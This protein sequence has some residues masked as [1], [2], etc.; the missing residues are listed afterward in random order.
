[1]KKP[2]VLGILPC[3]GKKDQTINV[4]QRLLYTA[5]MGRQPWKLVTVSGAEDAEVVAATEA[6]GAVGLVD[7]SRKKLSYWEALQYATDA[8]PDIP[9]LVNLANDVLPGIDWLLRGYKSYQHTFKDKPALVGFNGD[10]HGQEHSCHFIIHRKLLEKFG[11]WPVW[12]NHNFGDTELVSKAMR[13]S[14]YAKATFAILF[15]DHGTCK[16]EAAHKN[17]PVYAEG[18]KS[19]KEDEKL[20]KERVSKGFPEIKKECAGLTFENSMATFSLD[21][22]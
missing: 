11:G 13:D 1:M 18:R 9:L 7:R 21:K 6:Y 10:S 17:D 15:H 3:R 8:H 12:Y 14:V 5:P 22:I 20:F 19:F 4:V 16:G 2:Q